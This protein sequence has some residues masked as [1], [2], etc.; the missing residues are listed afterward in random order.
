MMS[1]RRQNSSVALLS[2]TLD[3]NARE[4]LTRQLYVQLRDLILSGRIAAGAGMPSTR[5]LCDD[6]N[7]SRTVTLAA[8]DQLSLEGYLLGS[9]GSGHIV[10]TLDHLRSA[11]AADAPVKPPE[12]P[13][14]DTAVRA[15]HLPFSPMCGPADLF[16]HQS[17]AHLLARG[18]RKHGKMSE[19]MSG[20]GLPALREAVASHLFSIKG[21]RFEP[22][23]ILITAGNSDAL[24]VIARSIALMRPQ[25]PLVAWIEDP[26]YP[27]SQRELVREGFALVPVPV[28]ADGMDVAAGIALAPEAA[29]A[30]LTPA[31]QFPMGMPLSLQRRLHL[32]N[33]ARE[34]GTVVVEDDYDSEIRFAGRPVPSLSALDPDCPVLSLGSLSKL[35]FDGLR[36][37]YVAG[38]VPLIEAMTRVREMEQSM[39]PTSAQPGM[40]EFITSGL[41]AKHLRQVRVQ[42]KRRRAA[43]INAL[44]KHIPDRFDCLPQEVGMHLTVTFRREQPTGTDQR[45]AKSAKAVGLHLEPLSSLFA[46]AHPRQGFI[47]G[48]AG[49]PEPVL[50]ESMGR[51]LELL[52]TNG[53]D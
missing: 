18:W 24:R 9:A 19:R 26:G 25:A 37:G 40:A 34:F 14:A 17:W 15:A 32:L 1:S 41:F 3:R 7:V 16:P 47:L 35:T 38:P 31:R 29:L 8:Y 30:L 45:I 48:Y 4:P 46:A 27:A 28:D 42:L 44:K 6:L 2:I 11:P 21:V 5:R 53:Y 49:W 52:R 43:L 50:E 51:F 13:A 39:V 23:Q 10:A 22:E 36:L 33:W 20:A 12:R